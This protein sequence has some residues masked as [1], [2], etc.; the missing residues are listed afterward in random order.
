MDADS[1]YADEEEM[2]LEQRMGKNRKTTMK[3]VREKAKTSSH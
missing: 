2:T 3:D 1:R